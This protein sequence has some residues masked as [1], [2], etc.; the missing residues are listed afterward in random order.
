MKIVDVPTEHVFP[1]HIDLQKLSEPSWSP[2]AWEYPPVPIVKIPWFLRKGSWKHALLDGNTRWIGAYNAGQKLRCAL[3]WL[4]EN[5]DITRDGLAP[6]LHA[7]RPDVLWRTVRIYNY[8][9]M[10]SLSQ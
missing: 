3:Y 10:K 2:M 6:F 1:F 9:I 7:A 8:L 4:D 5:I